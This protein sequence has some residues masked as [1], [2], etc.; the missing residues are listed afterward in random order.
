MALFRLLVPALP[1]AALA[2]ARLARHSAG[3]AI[4]LRSLLALTASIVVLVDTGFPARHVLGH[5]LALIELAS[6]ALAGANSVAA[7]DA[8]WVGVATARNIVDLAGVTDPVI[9]SLPGGHTSKR[10]PDQLL[11]GRGTDAWVLLLAP[12]A[13]PQADW[14]TSSFA[15]AVEQRL[16]ELPAAADF[17]LSAVLP[18]GGTRQRYIV[19]R[20]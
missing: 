10:I 15:R 17:K 16:A 7:L 11:V 5:R 19:V 2:A 9:A 3:W 20:R 18:L 1:T 13:T 8:G 6:S 14:R 4:A 12:D